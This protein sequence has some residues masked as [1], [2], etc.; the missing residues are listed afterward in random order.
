MAQSLIRKNI[1]YVPAEL[2][3]SPRECLLYGKYFKQSG[4]INVVSTKPMR[5]Y[6]RVGQIV[7]AENAT[8]V[9]KNQVIG[10]LK[11]GL[12]DFTY[13]SIK[14]SAESYGLYQNIFSRNKGILE[15][16]TMSK[17]NVA[18]LGC[19]SVG[20]L[21]AMELARS[22]VGSFLLVDTD[23]VE[24]HNVCRHQCGIDDVGD[25]KV[26]A[27]ARKI[28]NINPTAK[29]IKF[30]NK[31][32]YIPKKVFDKFCVPGETLFVGCADNRAADVY[33]NRI[34]AMYQSAF[35]SIGFWERAAAGELFYHL[36]NKN[37]PCYQCAVGARETNRV[38][39][40][41]RFY[42]NQTDLEKLNFEPG[43]SVDINFVTCI[44]IK[45]AIDILNL[46]TEGYSPR[47]L[48]DLKQ[49]TF[50]CNTNNPKIGGD[51]V[52]IF[53]YPLQVTTSLKVGFCESCSGICQFESE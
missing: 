47:L 48:N 49:Y 9:P 28:L 30:V 45:V 43:I 44:G 3:E 10:L 32:E 20:S 38:Q 31:V 46:N 5:G 17:K 14:L 11:E 18:I 35:L 7:L 36:P 6:K 12:I 27:L 13:N 34:T 24:Y 42:T 4:I 19:G 52:E 26:N 1:I 41:H 51:L 23:I 53:S 16:A 15:T 22:G 21:V 40:N 29:I 2:I 25:Y 8:L 37:L 33:T 50:V 39:G